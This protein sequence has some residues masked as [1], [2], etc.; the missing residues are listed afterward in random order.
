VILFSDTLVNALFL[1]AGSCVLALSPVV[2]VV[3]QGRKTR[4]VTVNQAEQVRAV[5][6]A[7]H[8]STAAAL[9][10]LRSDLSGLHHAFESHIET[11][12]KGA[13]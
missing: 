11:Y 12:H 7:E 1:F 8:S 9:E 4:A 10:G 2:V 6:T 3:I 13:A 5:N